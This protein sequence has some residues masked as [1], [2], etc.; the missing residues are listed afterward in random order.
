[1]TGVVSSGCTAKSKEDELVDALCGV[2]YGGPKT[3][4]DGRMSQRRDE[5][6]CEKGKCS[7]VSQLGADG[8]FILHKLT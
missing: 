4:R 7:E 5:P 3:A 6:S 1:M 8:I 2:N